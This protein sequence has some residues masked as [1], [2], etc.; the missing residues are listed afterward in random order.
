MLHYYIPL[1]SLCSS[2][3]NLLSPPLRTSGAFQLPQ[4]LEVG[5]GNDVIPELT[6][7]QDNKM[8]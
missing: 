6:V 7:L 4:K 3:A 1:H 5:A 2:D 8:Q